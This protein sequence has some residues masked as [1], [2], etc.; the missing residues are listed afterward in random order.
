[1]TFDPTTNRVPT[2]LLTEEEK[3]ALMA[4]PHGWER[5]SIGWHD[6]EGP[7]WEAW[8]VYRG[9]PGPVVVSKW[10]N[11][12][13]DTNGVCFSV[14]FESRE[15]ADDCAAYRIAVLRVD[16]CNGKRTYTE[17]PL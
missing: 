13:P 4:W 16:T 1:M 9:K 11:V 14:G 10:H 6:A 12:F 15:R 5:Y 3:Q 8:A 17:E 2:K 7:C